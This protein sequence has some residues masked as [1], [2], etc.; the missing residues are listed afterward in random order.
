M[1]KGLH[2]VFSTIVKDISQE[3]TNFG[4]SGSKV[5]H[6]IPEPRNFPEV[7]K[8][9]EN[10]RK[11]WLKATLKEINNLI[12]NQTFMIEDPNDGEPVTP[13]VDVYKAKI[14][15]DGSLDKLKLRIVAR[16]D[17][18]NKEMIGDTWSPTAS[19]RTLKYFPADTA[20]HKARVQQLD[21]IGEFL[22]AKV[23]N[24]VFVKLDMRYADYFPEYAQYFGR[25]FK[26]LKSMYGMANSGKLF[27]DE[28]T[29][30]LIEEGFMQ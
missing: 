3:L 22:Q 7:K 8:L 15:S 29:E 11:P 13:C 24:R 18:E 12:N 6:L 28:L 21:F 30:W 9:S 16:E 23:K 20:K 5:S 26:F 4:E 2:K 10:I 19:M 1:G 27:S 14:Q 25:A 17:L